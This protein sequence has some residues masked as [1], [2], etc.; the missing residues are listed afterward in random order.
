[1]TTSVK[2]AV[3]ALSLANL[4]F[5]RSW[6][7]LLDPIYNVPG[8]NEHL[9]VMLE[10]LLLGAVFWILIALARRSG[11]SLLMRIAKLVFP[12]VLLIFFN[13]IAQ[14]VFH[15]LGPIIELITIVSAI[16]MITVS[17]TRPWN[18]IILRS[19]SFV[20]LVL[21]PFFLLTFFQASRAIITSS[22]GPQASP[23]TE[24][25]APGRRV[26]WF[27]FDE[28]DQRAAF[29]QRPDSVY[30]PEFD[31]L[32]KEAICASNAYPP[33]DQTGISMPALI[34]GKAVTRAKAVNPSEIVI[35]FA[36]SGQPAR[37]SS[38]PNVF[39]RARDAGFNAAVTGWF[40][41]YCRLMADSLS[42]C[43][44]FDTSGAL[45]DTMVDNLETLSESIPLASS[46]LSRFGIRQ[47]REREQHLRMYS[48]VMENAKRLVVDSRLGLILVHLPVPHPPG[49]Y[50]RVARRFDVG[51][52]NSYLDNLE[53]ADRTLGELRRAMEDAGLWSDATVL[54]SSDH[55]WRSDYWRSTHLWTRE[56]EQTRPPAP[57]RRVPFVLKLPGQ[58]KAIEYHPDLSTVITHDL[59]LALLRAEIS[60]RD[61][62]IK[63]LYLHGNAVQA[64]NHANA[65]GSAADSVRLRGDERG[66]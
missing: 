57:D 21:F 8:F 23:P 34:T 20:T 55:A 10:V 41:P 49:I 38:E 56:D 24:R 46:G 61:D 43:Y 25:G 17:E 35:T 36:G 66:R 40:F 59:I 7:G 45:L 63:W 18:K 44:W 30:L 2:D 64:E 29:T 9:S 31:R 60:G 1:M 19:S 26:V 16:L 54:V 33:G 37:W 6:V 3:R 11:R 65:A 47:R 15:G 53:L 4:C 28:L 27:V 42:S 39:S 22:A 5:I 48:A 13:G 12:L 50:D 62:V 51:R 32:C 58:E 14:I 52:E